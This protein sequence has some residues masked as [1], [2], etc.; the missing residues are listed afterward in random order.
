MA[1]KDMA[2]KESAQKKFRVHVLLKEGV[3]DVQGKAVESSLP[4][5]GVSTVSQV[6][7]GKVIE[8][9]VEDSPEGSTGGD[10][11]ELVKKLCEELF[12]NPV[13][14]NYSFEEVA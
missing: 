10:Q 6:R 2:Q 9:V 14:E 11:D 3:L 1:Q 4:E 12:S 7:V 5:L 13:I 8:F